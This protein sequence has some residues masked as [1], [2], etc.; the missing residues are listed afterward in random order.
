MIQATMKW[1]QLLG[2]VFVLAATPVAVL[3][4][5]QTLCGEGAQHHPTACDSWGMGDS[6]HWWEYVEETDP[7]SR[8]RG[9]DTHTTHPLD[10][11]QEIGVGE[12][13]ELHEAGDC[14]CGDGHENQAP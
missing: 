2:A 6:C 3:A 10:E 1:A 14:G 11:N 9:G 12:F 5:W 4:A 8:E 7:E 13:N